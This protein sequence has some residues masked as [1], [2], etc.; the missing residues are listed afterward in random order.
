MANHD[1]LGLVAA[2]QAGVARFEM[3]VYLF[4]PSA[5]PSLSS[6]YS[7]GEV[8]SLFDVLAYLPGATKDLDRLEA[9]GDMMIQSRKAVGSGGR[10]DLAT[11]LVRML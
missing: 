8:P 11:Y 2:G 1:P 7:L 5:I 9:I 6:L 10:I 3:F 4:P